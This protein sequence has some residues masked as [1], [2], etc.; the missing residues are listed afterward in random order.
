M[1]YLSMITV[2]CLTAWCMVLGTPV[3]EEILGAVREV[4]GANGLHPRK[5]HYLLEQFVPEAAGDVEQRKQLAWA[6][7][8]AFASKDTTAAGR[9]IIA[10]HLAKVA[11]E[12]E[13]KALRKMQG[14]AQTL[15]DLRI[16]LNESASSSITKESQE[17]Y[18][19]EINSGIPSR[20]IAGLAGIAQFYPKAA[21]E[22]ARQS[23]GSQDSKV[24]AFAMRVLARN[25]PSVFAEAIASLPKAGQL[26]ALQIAGEYAV[27]EAGEI[28]GRLASGTDAEIKGAAIE[29]LGAIG[30]ADSVPLLTAAGA[31]DALAKLNAR[32]VD[33]AILK[34]VSSGS[35]VSRITALQAAEIRGIPGQEAVLL[36]AAAGEEREVAAEALKALGR[37]GS[38]AVYPELT[39]LLGGKASD[40][41]ELAVRRMIKR[42]DAT[43]N[44]L[45]PLLEIMNKSAAAESARIAVLRSLSAIGSAAALDIVSQNISAASA[46]VADAALRALA[47]WPEAS[48]VPLLKGVIADKNTSVVHRTL[49][50]RAAARFE[51]N[52]ARLSALATLNCGVEDKVKGRAGVQLAVT[53]GTAWKYT[54]EPAGTVAFDG[55][56]VVIEVSG[57]DPEKKYQVGFVWW[58]YDNN[59]RVQS[60][61]VGKMKVLDKSVLPAW[62]GKNQPAVSMAVTIPT[63]EIEKGRTLIRFIR[64]GAS[65]AV[66]SEVWI[67]EGEASGTPLPQPI[68]IAA[69]AVKKEVPRADPAKFGPPVVKA[70]QGAAKKVLIVTG[71]EYPGH[72]WQE[73]APEIVKL[74]AEDKRMEVSYT[75]DYTILAGKEIFRYDALFLNYQNHA[76]PGPAGALENLTKYIR[77][78]GGMTL[79]HFAC[80]AF[81]TQPGQIYNPQFVEIAG[82]SWNPKLRGHDPFGR[83]TVNITDKSHPI[84]RGL[85]D[86]E[87]EDELYTCLD[88]DAEIHLLATAV[89]KVDQKVYPMAFT[90]N[91]GKGRTFHCVLG[92][93]LKAF[94]DPTKELFRRGTAW[95]AG[96]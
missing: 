87:Q 2:V 71:L 47:Q 4:V 32:G 24:S 36:K 29:A 30:K 49:C 5:P 35:A 59:G 9:T 37:S 13:I 41:V 33:E 43:Q 83:F 56:E 75:E 74:L 34:A 72:P 22:I 1:K 7:M 50:E 86:F 31:V 63:S 46:E 15:A 39:A 40:E 91:P 88:G 73:T 81:I 23:V 78:G 62:K 95:S 60:V 57:L 14:D 11:G 45:P 89:S 3:P 48:A 18:S 58:D 42:M 69:P 38:T 8:E 17:V 96:L 10:Q 76:E 70:N 68:A 20:Q 26:S 12:A 19:A 65:N 80:G 79:F 84:T 53:R 85:E 93:N 44:P 51:A 92:H 77:E 25:K 6:L 94:N 16:A 52:G 55:S 64:E 90:V 28:A 82:R 66:V 21:A 67:A 27:T 54:D 61:A